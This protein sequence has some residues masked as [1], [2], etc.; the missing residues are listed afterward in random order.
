MAWRKVRANKGA[1]GVDG[2][3]FADI[4]TQDGGLDAFLAEIRETLKTRT[5]QPQPVRRVYIPKSN[6]KLRPLGIPVIRDR[7]VQ[8]ALLLVVEP[9]FEADFEECSFGFRP[10]RQQHM[11][12][13]SIW[14]ALKAERME[15]YDADLS[16]YFDTVDHA[17]LMEFLER[18]ISD[19]Q[20]LKLVRMWL[21][22]PVVEDDGKGG[23]KIT[24]PKAGVPQGGVISPLLSNV[25]LHEL[26]RDFHEPAGPFN[27]ASARLVRFAD[28]LV[29]MAKRLGLRCVEWLESKLE[30]DLGLTVNREKTS[31]V[32]LKQG[33]ELSFLGFTF[34][35]DLDLKGRGWRYIN[36]FPGKK[37]LQ[38]IRDEVR[39]LTSSGCKL[40]LKALVNEVNRKLQHW[41]PYYRYGY[42]RKA[43]RDLNHFVRCRF[44]RF[45]RNRSQRVSRPFR[46]G[47]SVYA[48]LQRY[49]LIT[50]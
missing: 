43:F 3:S 40:P 31:I 17:R 7:V 46:E 32:R 49:G 47:E 50:L 44:Q 48:G 26:D 33:A 21:R 39:Q 38:S 23:K 42:P 5:Y 11:A 30:K 10:G 13:E 8:A 36:V 15:V 18:R 28:D 6:G 22:S 35:Y 20:V 12:L 19:R 29:V 14:E 4:E 24:H 16:S 1:P 37:A 25:Y 34:R 27:F 45:L 41:A 9:I 2:V